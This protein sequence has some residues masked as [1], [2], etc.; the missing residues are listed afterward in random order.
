V[1]QLPVAVQRQCD[2]ACIGAGACERTAFLLVTNDPDASTVAGTYIAELPSSRPIKVLHAQLAAVFAGCA[3]ATSNAL[4]HSSRPF[5]AV[6]TAQYL[7]TAQQL[8][9]A[10]AMSALLLLVCCCH[11]GR[12]SAYLQGKAAGD[13]FC[14]C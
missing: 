13:G 7:T 4:P 14:C 9:A 10:P 3:A 11:D 5:G 1:Q 6:S 12:P 2:A 8:S